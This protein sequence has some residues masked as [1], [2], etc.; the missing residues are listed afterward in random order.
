[1]IISKY[2]QGNFLTM[3]QNA[4]ITKKLVLTALFCAL[5]MVATLFIRIPLPFGYVNLGDGFIFLAALVLGP[6]WGTLAA[7]VGSAMADMFGYITYAPATLIIKGAMALAFWVVYQGLG[8]VIRAE[9]WREIIAGAIGAIL[10]AFGYFVFESFYLSSIALAAVGAP[11]NL[12]QGG[13]G[14]AVS[15]IIAR[16]LKT[17]KVFKQ[18]H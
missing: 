8:K 16:I 11:W 6:I 18:F 3:K 2:R 4:T 13:V 14:V 9:L 17:T 12:W 5:I 7:G 1:M 15:V 10:M